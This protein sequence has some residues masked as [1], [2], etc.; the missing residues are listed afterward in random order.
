[1][2]HL[3]VGNDSAPNKRHV[4]SISWNDDYKLVQCHMTS[5]GNNKSNVLPNR[6]HIKTI[7]RGFVWYTRFVTAICI[8]I[9]NKDSQFCTQ[10]RHTNTSLSNAPAYVLSYSYVL[11]T[12]S[13]FLYE[14]AVGQQVCKF[15]FLSVDSLPPLSA[16]TYLS[17]TMSSSVPTYFGKSALELLTINGVQLTIYYCD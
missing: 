8:E 16:R 13:L 17:T 15:Q 4:I 11:T 7:G 3:C 1:M 6:V 14:I 9:E 2:S 5:L 10:P 12:S